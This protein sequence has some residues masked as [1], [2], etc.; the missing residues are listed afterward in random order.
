MYSKVN[1][2]DTAGSLSL[3]SVST[4]LAT[5]PLGASVGRSITL[6]DKEIK[7]TASLHD[8]PEEITIKIARLLEFRD[9]V[10]LQRVS[11]HLYNAI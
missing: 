7:K 10:S 9:I 5:E 4:S 3:P 11:V 1:N 2:S 8:L 6:P